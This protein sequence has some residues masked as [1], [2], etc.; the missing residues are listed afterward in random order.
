MPQWRGGAETARTRGEVVAMRDA[1][2]PQWRGSRET[3]R[4][5]GGCCR[6]CDSDSAA[7]E[8]QSGDCPDTGSLPLRLYAHLAAME[9]Q[10]GDCPD[11][12]LRCRRIPRIRC[13]NGGAVGRLPGHA[14]R[15]LG[16]SLEDMPQWRGSRETARTA[17]TGS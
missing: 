1:T 5:L 17:R 9:G 16:V 14:L 3:A 13:R 15:I 12:R 2:W 10:S 6:P 8:G 7:M 11:F 4:T